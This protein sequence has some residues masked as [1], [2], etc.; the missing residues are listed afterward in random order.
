MNM[1]LKT[2]TLEENVKREIRIAVCSDFHGMASDEGLELL[3]GCSPDMIVI[4]GDLGETLDSADGNELTFLSGCVAVAPT[5][6]ALGNHD[7]YFDTPENMKRITA[8]GVQLL[9]NSDI[10][11]AGMWIGGLSSGFRTCAKEGAF[12]ETPPPDE[13]FLDRFASHSG[14]KMLLS[15]HPEYYPKYIKQR[16]IPLTISGHAHGGQWVLFGKAVF[17][18]GQGIFPKYTAGIYENRLLVSR[19]MGN[20]TWV[21]RIGNPCEIVLLT[22]KPN[23]KDV[24]NQ[25][26]LL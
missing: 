15:H 8:T 9:N 14:F 18:P 20:H 25:G 2:C 5:F 13:H 10:F 12:K 6:Y 26:G 19:G 1:K 7:K 23:D 11:F 22:L 24:G 16:N 21:P 3:R 17:A 4:P